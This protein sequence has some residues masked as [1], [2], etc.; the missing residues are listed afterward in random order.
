M[1]APSPQFMSDYLVSPYKSL[2][3]WITQGARDGGFFWSCFL[4]NMGVAFLPMVSNPLLLCQT[5]DLKNSCPV[6]SRP[7]V[8][9]R[10]WGASSES[11]SWYPT[12]G[13]FVGSF[14]RKGKFVTGGPVSNPIR[15]SSGSGLHTRLP[16]P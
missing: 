2:R 7:E 8:L 5:G 14:W 15:Q 16:A 9:A 4:L 11:T 10:T 3:P 13:R 1:R 12:A 6:K